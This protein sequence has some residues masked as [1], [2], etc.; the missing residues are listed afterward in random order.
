MRKL[1]FFH[2]YICGRRKKWA[3]ICGTRWKTA[4]HVR[5]IYS[6][7]YSRVRL[8]KS[9]HWKCFGKGRD[10]YRPNTCLLT[11]PGGIKW[12]GRSLKTRQ[13]V[14]SCSLQASVDTQSL[15]P[16]ESVQGSAVPTHFNDMANCHWPSKVLFGYKI[17]LSRKLANADNV[18]YGKSNKTNYITVERRNRW[19]NKEKKDRN[20]LYFLHITD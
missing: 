10:W 3:L 9:A 15:H 18:I 7:Y 16:T 4:S 17:C 6:F 2:I 8:G 12:C 11:L 13:E 20:H 1:L 5:G 19:K 14:F